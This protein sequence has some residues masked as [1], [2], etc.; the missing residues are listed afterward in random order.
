MNCFWGSFSKTA[1]VLRGGRSRDHTS[2]ANRLSG[3]CSF[4]SPTPK[5]P[6][7]IPN[8]LSVCLWVSQHIHSPVP[9][10]IWPNAVTTY[11]NTNLGCVW[12]LIRNLKTCSCLIRQRIHST[13]LNWT[14]KRSGFY[15][16]KRNQESILWDEIWKKN[17]AAASACVN[18]LELCLR[19][20]MWS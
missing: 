10:L 1:A 16:N 15:D 4:L 2:S 18:L 9:N 12:W 14:C 19:F 6:C 13:G 8:L 7:C 11:P 17:K 20:S 3:D 5:I